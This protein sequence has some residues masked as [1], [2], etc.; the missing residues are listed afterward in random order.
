MSRQPAEQPPAEER[1]ERRGL[2]GGLLPRRRP[3][4]LLGSVHPPSLRFSQP[5]RAE[6]YVRDV[7]DAVVQG[8][9]PAVV[10]LIVIDYF[11]TAVDAN[12]YAVTSASDEGVFERFV[13]ITAML[14]RSL[15]ALVTRRLVELARADQERQVQQWRNVCRVFLVSLAD[16]QVKFLSAIAGAIRL[17][18]PGGNQLA[19]SKYGFV[20]L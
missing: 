9:P 7:V 14:N 15:N 3:H 10:A 13:H 5:E 1:R 2:L 8:K 20:R 17:N 18:R 6:T 4:E 16:A 19:W 12:L 11:Q